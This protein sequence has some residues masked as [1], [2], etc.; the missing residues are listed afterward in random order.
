M[1]ERIQKILA[2]RGLCSR[3]EA[4]E[5]ILE[6]RVT[7][8]GSPA[9]IGQLAE[10]GVDEIRV[11]DRPIPRQKPDTAAYLVNKPKG[12]V[13]TNRDPH[14]D[15]TVFHLLPADLQKEKL[16]CVG[17]LDK[18]SE[19]L[20]LLTNDGDLFNTLV[21]PSGGVAKRYLVQVNKPFRES[22]IPKLL[23]GITWEG[24]RLKADKVQVQA[25]KKG[26]ESNRLEVFL[27]HGKK[28]EIRRLLYAFGYSVKKLRRTHI[29]SLSVRG[30]PLGTYRKLSKKDF[31]KLRVGILN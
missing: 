8:N 15:R 1:N 16:F 25:T 30:I 9:E 19:G 20:V 24:E 31:E 6:G 13:C 28:R 10:P 3:R 17:R 23:R 21:H 4:E 7:V 14:A 18:E 27:H 11:D 29:G 12:F 2:N 22:D 5:W 26:E